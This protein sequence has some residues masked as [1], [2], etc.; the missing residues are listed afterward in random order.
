MGI[1]PIFINFIK[2]L[3][4]Q[5]TSMITNIGFLSEQIPLKRGLRQRCPPSLPL[6]VIQVTTIN[7]NNNN[8]IKGIHI[9]NK[10]KQTKISQY[11]DDSNLFLKN[12]ESLNKVLQF[13]EKLNKATGITINLEKTMVLPINT[14][15]TQQIKKQYTTNHN[16]ETIS[17]NKNFRNSLQ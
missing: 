11:T 14:E 13:F 7:I 1:S 17:N 9:P 8:S 10:T 12:Q 2:T 15:D 5:N 6:Y 4:K 16:Q 3:H